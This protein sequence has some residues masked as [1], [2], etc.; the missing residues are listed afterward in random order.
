MDGA[1]GQ[2]LQCTKTP[3]TFPAP[4]RLGT[5]GCPRPVGGQLALITI[6]ILHNGHL[7]PMN[8]RLLASFHVSHHAVMTACCNE[9][10]LYPFSPAPPSAPSQLP[11]SSV[12]T[13]IMGM[14]LCPEDMVSE[15]I[16]M[17][18]V[19]NSGLSWDHFCSREQ[20]AGKAE[21]I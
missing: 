11:L 6:I 15:G 20:E 12:Y 13:H 17:F 7:S 1:L 9:C 10:A 5:A 2:G 16:S 8:L 21:S 4:S 19:G 14:P 3:S 18:W